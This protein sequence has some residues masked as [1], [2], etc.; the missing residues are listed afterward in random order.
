MVT[1]N[2]YRSGFVQIEFWFPIPIQ[3]YHEVLGTFYDADR[4]MRIY[5]EVHGTFYGDQ[6]FLYDLLY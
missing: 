6:K 1:V 3:L 5:T 4:M 2:E